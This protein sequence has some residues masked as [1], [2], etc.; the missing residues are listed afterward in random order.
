MDKKYDI[1][2][3]PEGYKVKVIQRDGTEKDACILGLVK[4]DFICA[5]FLVKYEDGKQE[6]VDNIFIK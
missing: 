5:R 1:E 3:F 6:V 4:E 2:P